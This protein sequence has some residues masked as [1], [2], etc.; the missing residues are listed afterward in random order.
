MKNPQNTT[1][2]KLEILGKSSK[3]AKPY[4]L[5]KCEKQNA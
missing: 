3:E 4:S 2:F 1:I 5:G